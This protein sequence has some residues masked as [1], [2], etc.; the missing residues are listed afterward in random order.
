MHLL[1]A[2]FPIARCLR[3]SHSWDAVP[4]A[5]F[6]NT[7]AYVPLLRGMNYAVV[8][9]HA[10]FLSM[11]GGRRENDKLAHFHLALIGML[12]MG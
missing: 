1:N 9:I 11:Q 6:S 5:R 10:A 8:A 4:S 2:L 12:A 7:A 3:G